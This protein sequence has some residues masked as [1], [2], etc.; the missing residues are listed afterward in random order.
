MSIKKT[1]MAAEIRAV[2][3]VNVTTQDLGE[4]DRVREYYRLLEVVF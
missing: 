3:P 4:V 2:M 1:D